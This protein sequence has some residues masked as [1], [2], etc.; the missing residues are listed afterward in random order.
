MRRGVCVCSCQRGDVG[1]NWL[2]PCRCMTSS[3]GDSKPC[4]CQQ[5]NV[6]LSNSS[7]TPSPSFSSAKCKINTRCSA[8]HLLTQLA[9]GDRNTAAA[10]GKHT[11]PGFV[12]TPDLP[13]YYFRVGRGH[14]IKTPKGC[15]AP[16]LPR[17]W[18][19][20]VPFYSPGPSR[21]SRP[22]SPPRSPPYHIPPPPVE[23]RASSR[24]RPRPRPCRRL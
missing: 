20:W 19:G 23:K 24:S 5:R 4:G 2:G 16:S 7:A 12:G 8:V 10:H 15:D 13:W 14:Q 18:R 17:P 21:V 1:S 22:G 6:S 9:T 3:L 11:I